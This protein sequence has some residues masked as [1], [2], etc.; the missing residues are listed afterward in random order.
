VG[1]LA[2]HLW[3][4]T[5]FAFA[6]A[7]LALFVRKDAA[8][9][10]YWI[11]SAASIKFLVPFS[12]LTWI[13]SQFVLQVDDERAIL[14][15]V[16]HVAAPL[17]AV[18]IGIEPVT[19]TAQHVLLGL[20]LLGSC[21]FLARWIVHWLRAHKL[22]RHSVP[23]ALSCAL[24]SVPIPVRCSAA[25]LEPCVIGIFEPVLLLPSTLP[26]KLTPR[27]LDSLIAHELWHVRRRDNLTASVHSAIAVVFWFHPIVWWIGAKLIEAR[28]HACDEGALE[29][30]SEPGT[31]AGAILRVCEHSVNSRLACIARATG[32]D[33]SARIRSIMSGPRASRFICVRRAVAC[34]VLLGCAALPV[35]AGMTVISTSQLSVAAGT[36]SI[37]VSE[38]SG[39]AFVNAVDDH[40]Y[41]RNVSLRELI[42]HAYEVAARDV[43][44]DYSRL[45]TIRYDVDLR[46]PAGTALDYRQ[47]VAELLDQQ[48][49]IELVVRPAVRAQPH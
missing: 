28:E 23:C 31:Y 8:R 11:W 44:G 5:W 36:R 16:Q 29:E 45:D 3:Q 41:A 42:G 10:R 4:S 13:G 47:L 15:L 26:A 21:V 27:E 9:I 24:S 22:V 43:R 17:T 20:W 34:V 32:G 19:A 1:A 18:T 2:D 38:R 49:N 6:T 40:I 46:S 14:P 33:L 7:L 12:W 37:R 30:G 25:V 39:P 35:V 48:F